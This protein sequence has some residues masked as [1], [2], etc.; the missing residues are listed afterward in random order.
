MAVLFVCKSGVI[1]FILSLIVSKRKGNVHLYSTLVAAYAPPRRY[2]HM[3]G[4][5][6]A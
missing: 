3:Q 4:R 6:T 2:C 1:N 5:R